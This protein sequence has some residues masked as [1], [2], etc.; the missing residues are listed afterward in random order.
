A[1]G[2]G[3]TTTCNVLLG[4][5]WETSHTT[6]TTRQL[7]E[8]RLIVNDGDKDILSNVTITD[9]PGLGETLSRDEEYLNLYLEHLPYFDAIIWLMPANDRQ[10][11]L[12]Q[13][14]CKQFLQVEGFEDKVVFGLNKADLVE[15]TEWGQTGAN[16]PSHEQ[17]NNINY[18][19]DDF[20]AKMSS[21]GIKF[22]DRNRVIPFSAKHAWRVWEM[23]A[24]IRSVLPSAK[25]FSFSRYGRPTE[26]EPYK[27]VTTNKTVGDQ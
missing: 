26:W 22:L 23:F 6:A 7:Q 21:E 10:L 18:R 1:T 16:L 24:S 5:N 27:D 9:F 25:S 2:V 14:F 17:E 12:V 8:K 13:K 11:S 4:T 20:L 15:P 3:K 19:V